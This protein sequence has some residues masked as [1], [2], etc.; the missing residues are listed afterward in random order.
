MPPWE[1]REEKAGAGGTKGEVGPQGPLG[2]CAETPCF[3]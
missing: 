1:A 3:I 2:D